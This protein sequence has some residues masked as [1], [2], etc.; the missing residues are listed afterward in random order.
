MDYKKLS[1]MELNLL[2]MAYALPKKE[3]FPHPR[4][5][6]AAAYEFYQGHFV[7]MMPV[8]RVEDSYHLIQKHRIAVIPHGK[9]QWM[10]YHESGVSVTDRKPIRAAM[11]VYLML[12]TECS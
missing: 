4:N 6:R 9:T 2:V 12:Q 7:C 3:V 5:E 11:I 1:D 8:Q 10:A